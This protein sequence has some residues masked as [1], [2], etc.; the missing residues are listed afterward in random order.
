MPSAPLKSATY[1]TNLLR[2]TV[3]D[4]CY[5]TGKYRGAAHTACNLKLRLNPK[6]TTI[7]VVF[8]NLRG[9][10]TRL[11][12]QAI[13]KMDSRVSC[14]PNNTEKYI[15]SLEQ[16]R[17]IDIAQF[18][19]A[20]LRKLVAV[21]PPEAFQIT[22][23]HEPNRER[24]ELLMRKGVYPYEYMDTW[25]RFTEPR[26]PA[27]EVFYS[28]LSDAH[29]SDEDYTHAQKVW[30]TFRC[31]SLGDYCDLYCRTDVLLLADGFRDLSED[32]PKAVRPG[33]CLLLHQTGALLGRPAQ[34]DRR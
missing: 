18:L 31:L 22:A 17:F 29:I 2:V 21:N 26:L 16:L 8:H 11:L 33:P 14:I 6:T 24:R 19:L 3:R 4:H 7:P 15:S 13:S 10:D 32:L 27:K 20:S 28:K 34:E 25:D 5:I 23:Q 30:E 1:M 12:M 9:Y